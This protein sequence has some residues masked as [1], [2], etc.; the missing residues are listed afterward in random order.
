VSDDVPISVNGA[1]LASRSAGAELQFL[2]S[3]R[4]YFVG[5]ISYLFAALLNA[6]TGQWRD[7]Y[8][9][10]QQNYWLKH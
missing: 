2:P 3:C 4:A 5:T 1:E 9:R 10:I 6:E 7:C 8:G